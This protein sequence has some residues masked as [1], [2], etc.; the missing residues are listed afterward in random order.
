[1]SKT[2]KLLEDVREMMSFE[3]MIIFFDKKENYNKEA[4]ENKDNKHKGYREGNKKEKRKEQK[5]KTQKNQQRLITN[6]RTKEHRDRITRGEAPSPRPVKK[7]AT[8]VS[9]QLIISFVPIL[10]SAPI[11]FPPNAPHNAQRS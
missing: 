1:M 6:E 4:Q 3:L 2:L 7:S 10:K 8:K 9:K 5:T 11:T